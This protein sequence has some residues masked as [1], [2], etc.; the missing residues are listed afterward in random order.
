MWCNKF[1][2]VKARRRI[3]IP[4]GCVSDFGT[5]KC[6]QGVATR[7]VALEWQVLHTEPDINQ[8]ATQAI[9]IAL[10][11]KQPNQTENTVEVFSFKTSFHAQ[12]LQAYPSRKTA[13]AAVTS[14]GQQ[15]YMGSYIGVNDN[16]VSMQNERRV[17]RLP[18]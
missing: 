14:Y 9:E 13:R 2:G 18:Q 15:V 17:V 4:D 12:L 5:Q 3:Q 11:P 1:L 8:Q 10:L 6:K 7:Q 16:A